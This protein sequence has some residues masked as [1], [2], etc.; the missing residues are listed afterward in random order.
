[1]KPIILNECI[2][3]NY[4]TIFRK[5]IADRHIRLGEIHFALFFAQRIVFLLCGIDPVFCIRNDSEL[6]AGS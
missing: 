3:L 6:P 2:F 5:S 4:E 1:M